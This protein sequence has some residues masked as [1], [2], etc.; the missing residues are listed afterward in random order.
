MNENTSGMISSGTESTLDC[1]SERVLSHNGNYD[2]SEQT[3]QRWWKNLRSWLIYKFQLLQFQD[4][5]KKERKA[6]HSLPDSLLRDIGVSRGDAE[7]ECR[8][9]IDD[10][11]MDRIDAPRI[12]D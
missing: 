7:M 1:T 9:D 2:S 3:I 5:I 8:R 11:P 12:K 4:E 6:L 10:I